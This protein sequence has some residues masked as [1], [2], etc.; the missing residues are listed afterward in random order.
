MN[1][2]RAIPQWLHGQLSEFVDN[3]DF[4]SLRVRWRY[5]IYTA[6]II[7]QHSRVHVAAVSYFHTALCIASFVL[8]AFSSFFNANEMQRTK[9]YSEQ[10]TLQRL[11]R[12]DAHH[13]HETANKRVQ[14]CAT[15]AGIEN[16]ARHDLA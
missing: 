4:D 5:R 13:G 14:G 12:F 1:L 9:T 2:F 8:F 3:V 16:E 10:T 15:R 11:N 6:T 7:V